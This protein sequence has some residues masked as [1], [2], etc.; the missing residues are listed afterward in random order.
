MHTIFR[1]IFIQDLVVTNE[2][3]K[4]K[5]IELA[6]STQFKELFSQCDDLNALQ[7]LDRNLVRLD[8]TLSPIVTEVRR[9]TALIFMQMHGRRSWEHRRF[10]TELPPLSSKLFLHIH[11]DLFSQGTELEGEHS[12]ITISY[13]LHF[14][15]MQKKIVDPKIQSLLESAMDIEII[16]SFLK[17]KVEALKLAEE[18]DKLLDTT[19]NEVLL[20]VKKYLE[21]EG[22]CGIAG[23][24]ETADSGH[25]IFFEIE[26]FGPKGV[27]VRAYNTGAG[28]ESFDHLFYDGKERYPL[29][30]EVFTTKEKVLQKEFLRALIEMQTFFKNPTKSSE[31]CMD[32]A[33]LYYGGDDI[34]DGVFFFLKSTFHSVVSK[35]YSKDVELK[36]SQVITPQR[37]GTC[38]WKSLCALLKGRLSLE[39]FQILKYEIKLQT[40]QQYWAKNKPFMCY[41]TASRRLFKAAFEKFSRKVFHLDVKI[42]SAY[43]RA[44][45]YE[46]FKQISFSLEQIEIKSIEYQRSSNSYKNLPIAI[47]LNN[48]NL[49]V[50][51][52]KL[53]PE[54][55]R[56]KGIDFS[57]LWKLSMWTC[58]ADTIVED[59]A[60]FLNSIEDDYKQKAYDLPIFLIN[61]LLSRFPSPLTTTFWQTLP[62]D[63]IS[64]MV[65]QLH[66]LGEFLFRSSYARSS[67]GETARESVISMLKALVI[68]HQLLIRRESILNLPSKTEGHNQGGPEN[69]IH[70]LLFDKIRMSVFFPLMHPEESKE[71]MTLSQYCLNHIGAIFANHGIFFQEYNGAHTSECDADTIYIFKGL[72]GIPHFRKAMSMMPGFDSLEEKEQWAALYVSKGVLPPEFDAWRAQTI[73][74]KFFLRGLFL[75]NNGLIVNFNTFDLEFSLHE[76]SQK[77][78]KICCDFKGISSHSVVHEKE[79]AAPSKK[80][81]FLLETLPEQNIRHIKNEDLIRLLIGYT[82]KNE[83]E[84]LSED[85]KKFTSISREESLELLACFSNPSL[86]I[87]MAIA[88]FDKHF[89]KLDNPDYQIIFELMLFEADLLTN[90]LSCHP[91]TFDVLLSLIRKG[92]DKA[93]E[94]CRIE[95]A[96]FFIN[97]SRRLETFQESSL[98]LDTHRELFLL[99][100]FSLNDEQ[101]SDFLHTQIASYLHKTHIDEHDL[102]RI[103][104]AKIELRQIVVR[105]N[106]NDFLLYSES[107]TTIFKLVPLMRIILEGEEGSLLIR[108]ILH[109]QGVERINGPFQFT[110]FPICA[111]EDNLVSFNLINGSVCI[112]GKELSGLPHSLITHKDF[113]YH[114]GYAKYN[115]IKLSSDLYQFTDSSGRCC[116]VKDTGDSPTIQ[117]QI[118]GIWMEFINRDKFLDGMNSYLGSR[119]VLDGH[120]HWISVEDEIPL[121]L[122]FQKGATQPKYKSR[123]VSRGICLTASELSPINRPM[124]ILA[125]SE[126]SSLPILERI[127]H[128]HFMN[129]WMERNEIAFVELPRFGLSFLRSKNVME[130]C[131]FKGHRV[132][133]EQYL[134]AYLGQFHNFLLLE[135]D[136][137]KQL[138]IIPKRFLLDSSSSSLEQMIFFDHK[139]TDVDFVGNYFIYRFDFQKNKLNSENI[140]ANLYLAFILTSVKEYD[141]AFQYLQPK[142]K[143]YDSDETLLLDQIIELEK[144]NHDRFPDATAIR[145]HAAFTLYNNNQLYGG[146]TD[147][148]KLIAAY[149]EYLAI[150]HHV[151]ASLQIKPS[152]EQKILSWLTKYES[153][154]IKE[155]REMFRHGKIQPRAIRGSRRGGRI[156]QSA[157]SAGWDLYFECRRPAESASILSTRFGKSLYC[158]FEELY[159]NAL[160]GRNDHFLPRLQFSLNDPERKIGLL[161]RILIEATKNPK[162]FPK[163]EME[164]ECFEKMVEICKKNETV[165]ESLPVL[166][167]QH[168]SDIMYIPVVER[169]SCTLDHLETFGEAFFKTELLKHIRINTFMKSDLQ[170]E[171]MP[172]VRELMKVLEPSTKEKLIVLESKKLQ[173]DLEYYINNIQDQYLHSVIDQDRLIK[174]LKETIRVEEAR[175]SSLKEDILNYANQQPMLGA[176]SIS[177]G[178]KVQGRVI[179]Q[180]SIEQMIFCFLQKDYTR[181]QQHNPHLQESNIDKLNLHLGDLLQRMT[182]VQHLQRGLKLDDSNRE[183]LLSERAYAPSKHPAYLVFEYYLNIRLRKEQVERLDFMIEH[184]SEM[185]IVEMI[186]GFGKSK[187]LLPLLGFLRANGTQISIIVVPEALF[188]QTIF[189]LSVLGRVFSQGIHTLHFDRSSDCSEEALSRIIALLKKVQKE[190]EVLIMTSKD[191]LCLYLK[192]QE[193]SYKNE[194]AEVQLKIILELLKHYGSALLDEADTLLNT[195]QEVNFTFGKWQSLESDRLDVVAYIYQELYSVMGKNEMFQQEHYKSVILP[196]LMKKIGARWAD[197]D[198]DKLMNFLLGGNL[199]LTVSEELR[200]LL[201]LAKAQLLLL[202]PLTLNKNIDE[203]YGFRGT[204]I[205]AIPYVASNT[206]SLHSHFGNPYEIVNYTIQAY[207]QKGI[208]EDV[209][210]REITNLQKLALKESLAAGRV[211]ETRAFHLFSEI[212]DERD[213][214]HLSSKQQNDIAKTINATPKFLIA[215]VKHFILPSIQ[216]HATKVSGN[217]QDIVSLF[218]RVQGFTGTL[219]NSQTFHPSLTPVPEKGTN[220]RIL[221][222]LW[223]KLQQSIFISKGSRPQELIDEIFRDSK[224][225]NALA[226]IDAGG[227]FK[228]VNNEAVASMILEKASDNI[229]GVIIYNS[230]NQ[231]VVIDRLLQSTQLTDSLLKENERITFYDQRHTIGSDITQAHE[232]LGVVLLGKNTFLRELFQSTWRMR[233]IEQG[234]SVVFMI[235]QEIRTFYSKDERVS[236]AEVIRACLKHQTLQQGEDNFLSFKHKIRKKL[237][238]EALKKSSM[239][240]ITSLFFFSTLDRPYDQYG[241]MSQ[242]V[243]CR[244]A[245]EF[246]IQRYLTQVPDLE[247]CKNELKSLVDEHL[248]PEKLTILKDET[249][250]CVE[251]ELH[252][253]IEIEKQIQD[254]RVFDNKITHKSLWDA[255]VLVDAHFVPNSLV[256]FSRNRQRPIFTLIDLFVNDPLLKKYYSLIPRNLITSCNAFYS[257][258][259]SPAISALSPFSAYQKFIK[260]ICVVPSGEAFNIILLDQTD[261][262]EIRASLKKGSCKVPCALYSLHGGAIT[263]IPPQIQEHAAAIDIQMTQL[264]FFNGEIHYSKK[265]LES[266]KTWIQSDSK[267]FFDLFWNVILQE[268][269]ATRRAYQ[270]SS[271][272]NLFLEL[273]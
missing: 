106:N 170:R 119:C 113:I 82:F 20:V 201:S 216:M 90:E 177:Q 12:I 161:S 165:I 21:K 85:L 78:D 214:M 23:G 195:R 68:M 54:E 213:L 181:Y 194:G 167:I 24:W 147:A 17:S 83:S 251:I 11:G 127:E 205:L 25:T 172:F 243:E 65:K 225:K 120:D 204:E 102:V 142:S 221:I 254:V 190:R 209:I 33:T 196:H 148:K 138:V 79:K 197:L 184:S 46:W 50:V 166:Q 162:K 191:L 6:Q 8:P 156:D 38:S 211:E 40:L 57:P 72:M 41:E 175:I 51:L 240:Q 151:S 35:L 1:N 145:L 152:A 193:A 153:L 15:K 231:L 224:I 270:T 188:E 132:V 269:E 133:S 76:Y 163:L 29:Y 141:K 44:Q 62:S 206:P 215:F 130:S 246:E 233:K 222:A 220:A 115:A 229:Q 63:A 228:G 198:Q 158:R 268:R 86:Q 173:D 84:L 248:L 249:D 227:C 45:L 260:F 110:N 180:F 74:T 4:T 98:F 144:I 3:E 19:A 210:K 49:R 266:L 164:Y 212:S 171:A 99:S 259:A 104:S 126:K 47:P 105:N 159:Q 223:R 109:S 14:L 28:I 140:E 250:V 61:T 100:Q 244:E 53:V 67:Q 186:M 252:Q 135:N 143:R 183:Q 182:F 263:D 34:L 236:F 160:K 128:R 95:T 89:A 241:R 200:D 59:C 247:Y 174:F 32:G 122:I 187:V 202:L 114:F 112:S 238:D 134:P 97:L 37:G 92:Y 116:H 43:E 88:Y 69:T 261:C 101:R 264:K 2:V 103:L 273:M 199:E 255:E 64:P 7:K 131:E 18:Q 13:L 245:V 230:D 157:Y 94:Y 48:D 93:K 237:Q 125:D 272:A 39:E 178:F 265:E 70:K 219:W 31:D 146:N 226:I 52:R 257:I 16:V 218:A 36:L 71:Y 239:K 155:R 118:D 75:K 9:R 10:I 123:M 27:R 179:D 22:L 267:L 232:A 203:Q 58:S 55:K 192:Y 121:M 136:E 189:D 73:L 150:K 26:S 149:E 262:E 107:Q 56:N 60:Q 258:F 81:N 87:V 217:S 42:V 242:E 80:G 66:K 207:L 235:P 234:Q 108:Q 154:A 253:E 139:M 168:T 77:K 169:S 185:P 271:I 208:P 256:A 5:L 129:I 96:L 137:R 117:K 91:Q 176:P 111:T 124:Q 30:Y